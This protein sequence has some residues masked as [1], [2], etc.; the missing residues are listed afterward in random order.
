MTIIVTLHPRSRARAK[1]GRRVFAGEKGYV[2]LHPR[3]SLRASP[4]IGTIMA[5]PDAEGNV[6][7]G[8]NPANPSIPC[9]P[10]HIGPLRG[11]RADIMILDDFSFCP[12]EGLDSPL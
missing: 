5:K 9:R 4:H 11:H 3:M 2:I 1:I 7:I 6:Q 12:Q 8:I 10:T